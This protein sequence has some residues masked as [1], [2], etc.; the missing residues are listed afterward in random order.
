MFMFKNIKNKKIFFKSLIIIIKITKCGI[1]M[2]VLI[3]ALKDIKKILK[4]WIK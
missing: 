1:K 2:F 4:K 3:Y